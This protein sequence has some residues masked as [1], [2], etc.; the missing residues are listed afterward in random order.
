VH[1]ILAK[2]YSQTPHVLIVALFVRGEQVERAPR[3]ELDP[4]G[5]AIIEGRE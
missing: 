4:Y 2:L 5:A 3:P 1:D